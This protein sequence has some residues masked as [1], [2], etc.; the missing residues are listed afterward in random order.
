MEAGPN[1]ISLEEKIGI[2]NSSI[3]SLRRQLELLGT[4]SELHHQ[5]INLENSINQLQSMLEDLEQLAAQ[6]KLD[7]QD[8]NVEA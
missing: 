1:L 8:P 2:L 3:K 5:R 6:P 4:D 7:E